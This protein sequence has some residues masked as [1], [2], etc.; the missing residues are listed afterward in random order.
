MQSIFLFLFV[1]PVALCDIS[2]GVG[3]LDKHKAETRST[4]KDP[5]AINRS[6]QGKQFVSDF[7]QYNSFNLGP[8]TPRP[9]QP[10]YYQQEQPYYGQPLPYPYAYPYTTTT[11]T[12]TT[13][14]K[15]VDNSRPVGY[16][17]IDTHHTW[18]GSYSRPVAFFASS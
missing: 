2:G 14:A 17:L 8:N 12:T 7:N 1:L 15:P 9:Y 3:A 11:T 5:S 6:R 18:R 4:E 10:P 16:M 13:T